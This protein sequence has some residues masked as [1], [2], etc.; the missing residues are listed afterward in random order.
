MQGKFKFLRWNSEENEL[1][2]LFT[3][4]RGKCNFMKS[5]KYKTCTFLNRFHILHSSYDYILSSLS[6]G[7]CPLI[8]ESIGKVY[9]RLST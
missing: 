7:M 5:I 4:S 3:I 1:T 2:V 8:F 6:F 9:A